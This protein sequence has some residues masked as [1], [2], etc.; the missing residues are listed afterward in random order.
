MFNNI[1]ICIFSYNRPAHL[2]NLLAS[3]TQFYPEMDMVIFDD[4][5]DVQ[6][7][8]DLLT[9]LRKTIYVQQPDASLNSKHGG[10]YGMMNAALD[11]AKSKKYV[12][13]YFVQDDM[14]FLWRD[15]KLEERLE[16]VFARQD[17]LM[18]NFNFLRKILTNGTDKQLP[19]IEKG[20]FL[21]DGNGVADT[22]II[23]VLKATEAG[24]HFL[25]NSESGNGRHWY[26]KGHRLYWLPVPHLAWVPW[27]STYRYKEAERR[28]PKF[29]K[30]LNKHSIEK[31][32]TNTKYAYLED[33]TKTIRFE[34][35]P[36]WYTVNPGTWSLIKIY[37]KYYLRTLVRLI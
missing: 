17:C 28:T 4:N 14:Q 18:C 36:Y 33:Y 15:E 31:L 1:L 23:D 34:I 7:M 24:L 32:K 37:I 21:F 22:G 29:L 25:K 5:S 20:I 6:E 16:T 8:K 9:Q 35:K 2:K 19:E 3:I 10:L 27:P 30:P 12:Y 26:E 11:Y 13:A